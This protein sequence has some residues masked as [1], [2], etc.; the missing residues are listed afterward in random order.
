MT[1]RVEHPHVEW[2]WAKAFQERV[3]AGE[4]V[5]DADYLVFRQNLEP[6][7]ARLTELTLIGRAREADV[8][9]DDP[10]VSRRHAAVHRDS[11][12]NLFLEDRGSMNGVYLNGSRIPEGIRTELTM[13]D[14]IVVG[15]VHLWVMLDVSMPRFITRVEAVSSDLVQRVSADPDLLRR[16]TPRQFEEVMAELYSRQGL[17]VE[18]T[19]PTRDGGVDLYVVQHTS[20]GRRL[21]VVDCKQYR[22]DRLLGVGMVRQLLGTV[23]TREA[24]AG[25]LATTSFFTRGAKEL[26]AKYPFRL[27][28]Q[29]YH[30]LVRLIERAV[31]FSES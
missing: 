24:S 11:V 9:L 2:D 30:D 4:V 15:K 17:T 14:H 5:A 1:I 26:Q 7:V 6:R 22:N 13:S 21:T 20:L 18:L 10:V 3:A 8:C 25:V 16:L 23:A 29:D 28:L 12:G 31:P 19:P 27:A